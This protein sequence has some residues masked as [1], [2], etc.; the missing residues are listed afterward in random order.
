MYSEKNLI[1]HFL[2]YGKWAPNEHTSETGTKVR[3]P[4]SV[5]HYAYQISKYTFPRKNI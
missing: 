4:A 1:F 2:V 5:D 3:R